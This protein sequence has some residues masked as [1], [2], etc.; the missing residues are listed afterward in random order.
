MERE[1]NSRRAKGSSV[2]EVCETLRNDILTHPK[3]V[4]PTRKSRRVAPLSFKTLFRISSC[5]MI[6]LH[7]GPIEASSLIGA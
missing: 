1:L 6:R 3:A 4:A 5:S 7:P 2:R